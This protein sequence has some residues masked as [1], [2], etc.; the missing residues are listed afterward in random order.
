MVKQTR[1]LLVNPFLNIKKYIYY[2]VKQLKSYLEGAL[3]VNWQN[4][5]RF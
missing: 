2:G 4:K 5:L 3:V 1:K